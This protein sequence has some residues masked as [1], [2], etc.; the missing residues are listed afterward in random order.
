[1]EKNAE[2]KLAL[3]K[4]IDYNVNERKQTGTKKAAD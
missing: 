2:C 4:I 1:M 3:S